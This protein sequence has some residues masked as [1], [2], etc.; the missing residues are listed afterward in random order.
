MFQE[1]LIVD[2]KK[3]L[4]YI[5]ISLREEKNICMENF[6]IKSQAVY[7]ECN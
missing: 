2:V 3:S 6:K 5:K 4:I 1:P 7:V